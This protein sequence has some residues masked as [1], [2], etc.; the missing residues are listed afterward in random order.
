MKNV[1]SQELCPVRRRRRG[2]FRCALF[3]EIGLLARTIW[4][5][6]LQIFRNYY[7]RIDKGLSQCRHYAD[8]GG[9]GQF[10]STF[11]SGWPLISWILCFR[12]IKRLLLRHWPV[13]LT[14]LT[15]SKGCL[16]EGCHCPY[17]LW[18]NVIRSNNKMDKNR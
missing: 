16:L 12:K 3:R 8:K 15:Q 18:D 10:F 2:F 11:F 4:W 9:G 17:Y 1:R 7:V 5:K 6:K 14:C 13:N